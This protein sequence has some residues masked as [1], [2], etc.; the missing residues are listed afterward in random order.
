MLTKIKRN[1]IWIFLILLFLMDM[2]LLSYVSESFAAD[3]TG[4]KTLS[5][6]PN[7]PV[8]YAWTLIAGFL[9]MFMQAGFAMLEAGLTRIKN[10]TNIIM[11]NLIDFC[12][13][14]LAYWAVGFALMFGADKLGIFGTTNW[15]LSG[16]AYDVGTIEL[17]F[18]QLVFAATAATIVSGAMAER[19]KFNAYVLYSIFISA[20]IYPLYGHWV[21]GGGWLAES[22]FMK[23]LG[24]G[25]GALDFAGSGVVHGI[26][27]YVA[28]AGALLLGPR[29][30]KY[31]KDGSPNAILGHN[32]AY[33]IL[34]VFILWF[35]WFG[36]NAGSTLAATELRI[37]IIATNTTLAAAAGGT[38]VMLLTWLIFGKPDVG[39][40]GNGVV[41]GLVA[42]TAPCAWVT[43][44][45]AVLIGIIGGII[46]VAGVWF[47]DWK[48]HIDDPV[49]AIAVHGLNGS[50]GLLA[51]GLFADGTYGL[52]T[53]EGPMVTG[54]FYGN[55]GFFIVQ[56]ISVL[57]N[58][59]WGFGIGL[60]LFY[61]LKKS[62]GIR[63]PAEEEIEGLDLTEHGILAYPE[64]MISSK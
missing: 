64:F 9:V 45:A 8:N 46:I 37:S 13:G 11:K 23:S 24:G 62:I 52:Y 16:E 47:I 51:L 43:P 6:D 41:G 27:G 56:L 59:L 50:W 2:F 54:L 35:G 57:T 19:T 15:F 3:P 22:E 40:T 60:I 55:S 30:G 20:F 21:W 31:N 7:S 48:L 61:I 38:T 1:K 53:T 10:T 63:V 14:S 5:E 34:G 49:G 4:A 32:I 33:A 29:I 18:F 42:I 12:V 36:F 26:G 17:W 58:F 39:M 44:W 28:L 25:Y